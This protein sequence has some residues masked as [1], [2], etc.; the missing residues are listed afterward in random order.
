MMN[1]FAQIFT[2]FLPNLPVISRE[3]PS[4]LHLA[5]HSL[6]YTQRIPDT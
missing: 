5:D 3:F 4:I 2:M 6:R 1:V